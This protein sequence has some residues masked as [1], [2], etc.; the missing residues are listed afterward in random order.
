MMK[1]RYKNLNRN[2]NRIK[3]M[4]D[5]MKERDSGRTCP[6]DAAALLGINGCRGDSSRFRHPHC[7]PSI[8]AILPQVS[9]G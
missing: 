8:E 5:V 4:A 3:M 2:F 1:L 7:P 9:L 6:G